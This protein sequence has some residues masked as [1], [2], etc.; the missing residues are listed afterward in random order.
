MKDELHMDALAY[1]G[2]SVALFLAIGVAGLLLQRK[3]AQHKFQIERLAAKHANFLSEV[4]G[5]VRHHLSTLAS[6]YKQKTYYDEYSQ[7]R[8]ETWTVEVDKFIRNFVEPLARDNDVS[9]DLTEMRIRISEFVIKE[10]AAAPDRYGPNVK[11]GDG[12]SFEQYCKERL[13]ELGLEVRTTRRGADQ[14]VDLIVD[15]RDFRAALQC[16]NYMQPVGNGAVQ[17]ILAGAAFYSP[18]VAIPVVISR[19]GFTQ[20][21]RQLAKA[22]D[23][24]LIDAHDIET[25][26]ILLIGEALSRARPS[27]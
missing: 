26:D 2:G 15:H 8:L 18:P 16:K 9:L 14:G 3:A 6:K 4:D 24:L 11:A 7:L 23:V 25:F 5:V 27:P 19:S 21:A 22:A 10:L 13:E 12:E 1:V 17:E 20:S